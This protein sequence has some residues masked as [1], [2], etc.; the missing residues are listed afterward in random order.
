[1][2]FVLYPL[3]LIFSLASPAWAAIVFQNLGASTTPDISSNTD[4]VSY[5][6]AS[7]TP[8]TSGLIIACVSSR[9]LAGG[10]GV[11]PA[12]TGNGLT[13]IP[14]ETTTGVSE[15]RL[16]MFGA[17]ATGSSA[18]ATTVTFTN[19]QTHAHVSFFHATGV[20][21]SGGVEAAFVQSVAGGASD[22]T[23]TVAF[24]AAGHA[25]NRPIFCMRNN[26]SNQ[27]I[28]PRANWTEVDELLNTS[29]SGESQYRSDA[30]ETTASA[31][32]ATASAWKAIG[33]ELKALTGR[34]QRRPV[35][36]P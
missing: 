4:T 29:H 7:W 14:I 33:A 9:G 1:M 26:V 10:D 30:F 27:E 31:T 34:R 5:A 2:K 24:A 17:N 12:I 15:V 22:T 21:L 18:G 13:W 28:T 19:T 3:A 25:D 35:V 20:D 11:E 36:F 16:T 8:P 32:F 6:S 23:A